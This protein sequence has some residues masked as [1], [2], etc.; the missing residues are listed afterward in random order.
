MYS[1]IGKKDEALAYLNDAA[2]RASSQ[3]QLSW[4]ARA[5]ASLARLAERNNDREGALRYYM[6]VSI[7]FNDTVLVP[8]CMKKAITIL[9]ALDRKEEA[10]AMRDELKSRFPETE[11]GKATP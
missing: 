6:S 3:D 11:K 9:D 7:L 2:T 10:K 4:R 5:Y 8:A 1:D